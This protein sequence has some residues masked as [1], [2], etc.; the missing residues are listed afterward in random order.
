MR[1]ERLAR[2][3]VVDEPRRHEA[4]DLGAEGIGDAP[5]RLPSRTGRPVPAGERDHRGRRLC[6]GFVEGVGHRRDRGPVPDPD[7]HPVA[8]LVV[9][10]L[11][12]EP[13][14]HPARQV[15]G[16]RERGR[17]VDRLQVVRAAELVPGRRLGSG[18][19][20]DPDL[21]DPLGPRALEQ[22]RHLRP[23]DA[24]PFGDRVLRL[25]ELVVQ[26]ARLDE[27]LEV[28]HARPPARVAR[29]CT[30]VL[31]RCAGTLG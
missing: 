22:A 23:R 11:G 26:A 18:P 29:R 6:R 24:Q 19:V 13:A 21:D 16:T 10:H 3:R 1:H 17:Q 4:L 8:H 2:G 27:L 28:A 25:A 12:G 20:D 31:N 15:L 30:F 14:D 7:D 5:E 9:Q